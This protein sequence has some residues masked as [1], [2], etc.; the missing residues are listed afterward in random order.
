[1]YENLLRLLTFLRL[2]SISVW[3]WVV[4]SYQR[5]CVECDILWRSPPDLEEAHTWFTPIRTL[6]PLIRSGNHAQVFTRRQTDRPKPE[7]I[8]H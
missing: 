4:L 1:M 3:H 2:H 7:A 6:L 5:R 8:W